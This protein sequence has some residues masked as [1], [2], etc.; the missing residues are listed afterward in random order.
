ML[1]NSYAMAY[2][3]TVIKNMLGDILPLERV[4]CG[5]LHITE[6]SGG[7]SLPCSIFARYE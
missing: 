1:M 2:S 7:R 4:T 3:P 6:T 5:E